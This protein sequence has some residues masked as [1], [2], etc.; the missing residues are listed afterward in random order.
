MHLVFRV[1]AVQRM[2]RRQIG[3]EDV[4][5]AL[6]TGEIIQ[7]YPEDKPYPSRLVLGWCGSTPIH[8]VAADSTEGDETFV[9]TVYEPTLELWKPDFREKRTF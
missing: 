3:L 8:V 2:F 1:H 4:R 5:Y 7:D 6:E 9:I